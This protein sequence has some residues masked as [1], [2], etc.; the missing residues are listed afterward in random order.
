MN[1]VILFFKEVKAEFNKITWPKRAELV[2]STIIVF[3]LVIFFSIFLGV[4]DLVFST[5]IKQLFGVW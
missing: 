2:G 1:K 3:I 5:F 4:A